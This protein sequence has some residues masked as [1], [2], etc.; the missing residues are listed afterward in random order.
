MLCPSV[1]NQSRTVFLPSGDDDASIWAIKVEKTFFIICPQ[2]KSSDNAF[3]NYGTEL[4]MIDGENSNRKL[5]TKF[6]R[7]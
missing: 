5:K 1:I 6:K 3:A 2:K 7:K 4:E